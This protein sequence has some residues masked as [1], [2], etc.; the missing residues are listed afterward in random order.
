M[1]KRDEREL[2]PRIYICPSTMVCSERE[3]FAF[4]HA[5]AFSERFAPD[6]IE[7]VPATDLELEV[8]R[9]CE[10]HFN[11][12]LEA[13]KEIAALKESRRMLSDARDKWMHAHDD[14]KAENERLRTEAREARA[15]AFE[16]AAEL[17]RDDADCA[18]CFTGI[19]EHK[20]A[21]VRKG[22]NV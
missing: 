15:K 4:S 16:E 9:L 14:L 1:T 18:K 12:M 20:A 6:E 3:K 8:A 10:K 19:F 17:V 13:K 22:E 11:E 7:Y 5:T 2:P 21:E